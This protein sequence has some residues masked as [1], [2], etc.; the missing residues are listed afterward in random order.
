MSITKLTIITLTILLAF[1]FDG[2][3]LN[4]PVYNAGMHAN[5]GI[6]D[7]DKIC[8]DGDLLDFASC[9]QGQHCAGY[10]AVFSQPPYII[11]FDSVSMSIEPSDR[12][13]QIDMQPLFKPPRIS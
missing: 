12:W 3:T 7:S 9:C 1:L 11:D 13:P 6:Q 10:N 4:S 2:T 5:A 8:S